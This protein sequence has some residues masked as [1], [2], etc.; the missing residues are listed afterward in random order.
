M[1]T[2]ED[3]RGRPRTRD[4]Y[5]P[6]EFIEAYCHAD[7]ESE[8][9]EIR[10][11]FRAIEDGRFAKMLNEAHNVL[12]RSDLKRREHWKENVGVWLSQWVV[13]FGY[14]EDL[15]TFPDLHDLPTGKPPA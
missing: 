1:T 12:A 3:L 6:A 2:L 9:S 13:A 10:D 4:E 14:V 5:E 7:S 15:N 11:I 8:R